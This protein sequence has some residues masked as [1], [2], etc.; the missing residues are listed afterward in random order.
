MS[1]ESAREKIRIAKANNSNQLDLFNERLTDKELLELMPEI[2]ELKGLTSLDLRLNNLTNYD[3]LKELKGL[4]SLNLSN[5]NLTNV[6]FLK[7]LKGLTSLNLYN[8]NL[9]NYDFLKELKGLT[10]LYLNDNNLTNA[11]FLKELKGLTS[12]DLSNNNLTDADFLKELINLTRI[13]LYN[14]PNLDLPENLMKMIEDKGYR[15]PLNRNDINQIIRYYKELKSQG[16]DYIYEARV[17]IVGEP[18]AGKT[19]LF[20]KLKDN[21]YNPETASKEEKRSTVG[22]DIDKNW[23]FPYIKDKTKTFT[24]HLWDFGGQKLQYVL[25]QYFLTERSLYILLADDRRQR[26]NFNYWFDVI[27]TL[28]KEC[29]VLVVLNERN[30]QGVTNISLKKYREQFEDKIK[31]L[32]RESV[33][34][35]IDTDGRFSNLQ[36]KIQIKLSNLQHIGT[37]VPANWKVIREKLE[38]ESQTKAYILLDEYYE[39]CKQNQLKDKV[40]YDDLLSYFH[41]LG[42]ALN[43]KGD[44]NLSE[45]VILNPNWVID[46]LYAVLKNKEVQNNKGKF[47]REEIHRI[48]QAEGYKKE[49]YQILLSLMLKGKFEIA[50]KLKAGF[51]Y[52]VPILLR[53]EEIEDYTFEKE[54]LL[55]IYLQYTFMP[56]G[57]LSRLIVRQNE[58]IAEQ[59]NKQIV[60]QKGVLL[61]DKSSTA[62]ITEDELKEKITIKVSGK[63]VVENKEFI[64]ILRNEIYK[65]HKDWFENNLEV[66]EFV[67]CNCNVCDKSD[68]K[69][70]FELKKLQQRLSDKEQT[71]QCDKSYKFMDVRGLLEGIY[72]EEKQSLVRR[73]F[74]ETDFREKRFQEGFHIVGDIQQ[75]Y[76][77]P[78]RDRKK[79]IIEETEK[80]Q[81]KLGRLESEYQNL[82][83]KKNIYDKDAQ[84]IGRFK[85]FSRLIPLAVFT[86]G[87]IAL[88]IKLGWNDMEIWTYILSIG[89]GLV[90]TGFA[91]WY[92]D[93]NYF[94]LSPNKIF[95]KEKDRIYNDHNFDLKEFEHIETEI[96]KAKAT[97]RVNA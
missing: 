2:K 37:P 32:D 56:P 80:V 55:E 26:E 23:S 73:Q 90:I 92:L 89:I 42:I 68:D 60:W 39:I 17:L 15:E 70:F 78:I 38:V 12:L 16:T 50:Y 11:D 9:T 1:L 51:S 77:E 25:H 30:H 5:N 86:L 76:I 43:Y 27:A 3:F 82:Q 34:F 57:I 44:E 96:T 46:A 85:A 71:I 72:V 93:D 45:I 84:T 41:D 91:C 59:N 62:E 40:Y 10:S 65:I 61:K 33:D 87:W 28:G 83:N 81:N 21:S 48:W 52:I 20:K 8:N 95:E 64:T 6:E 69:Q 49:D 67:P 22:I 19:T 54:N 66:N 53:E 58:L 79:E 31:D 97:L 75:R 88:V 36:N 14:N 13:Y 63:N 18:G 7:E 35:S 29:P 74:E 47:T 94:P 24:A 4:T